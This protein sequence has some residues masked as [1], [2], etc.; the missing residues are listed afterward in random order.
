MFD[1]KNLMSA[2]DPRQGRYL[3]A[4]AIFRGRL[5]TKEVDEQMANVQRRNSAYFVPWIPNNVQT[6]M[7]D[8]PPRGL[9]MCATFVGNNTAIAG[10]PLQRIRTQFADMYRRHAFV[11]WYTGEGMDEAE[12]AQAESTLNDLH[13]EYQQYQEATA[14]TH[15]VAP[16]QINKSAR[17]T[18]T[19]ANTRSQPTAAQRRK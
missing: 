1:A 7:C 9:S 18:V 3:A 13:A 2:C 15:N 8:I 12:F 5:S 6:A 10:G 16:R 14:S 4:A 19:S 11:H 17:Q